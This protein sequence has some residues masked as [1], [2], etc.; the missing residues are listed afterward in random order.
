MGFGQAFAQRMPQSAGQTPLQIPTQSSSADKVQRSG[1]A[2]ANSPSGSQEPGAPESGGAE[3]AQD[4]L[5]QGIG[6]SKL[7]LT[8]ALVP[9]EGGAPVESP[10]QP[11]L[12]P[13]LEKNLCWCGLFTLWGGTTRH[14][15]A[16][17]APQR[18]DMKLDLSLVDGK[19]RV[20]LK[21]SG[22]EGLV[23][24]DESVSTR[25]DEDAVMGLVNRLV[26]RITGQPG[27]LGST[28]AFAMSQPG[29]PKVV[30]ATNTH[31]QTL[32]LV[33]RNREINILPR[34][35]PTGNALVYTVLGRD[36]SRVYFHNLA[37]GRD[38][39][40]PSRF[41]TEAG[42]LNT[43]GTFSPDGR[44]LVFTMSPNQNADLFLYDLTAAKVTQITS[45]IGIETQADWG[46]DGKQVLFV[47]DRSG[48]PQIYLMDLDTRE[49]LRLTFDGIYNTDPR[50]SPDGR[51]VLF[52]RRV[53][54]LD[55]IFIMDING[56]NIRPVTRGRFDAEQ[57]VWSPDGRQ[58]VFTSNRTG[59]YKLYVVSSDGSALR[60]LTTT[61]PGYEE[62]NPGW[63]LRRLI[64]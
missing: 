15:S 9:E 49:D 47:S 6:F 39:L 36:G 50:F 64:R 22:A 60:R 44:R 45:R 24:F 1:D 2:S 51:L 16:S 63:T 8:L 3:P 26:E 42:S 27:I 23:L 30:V 21:D 54:N 7:N 12:V 58:I 48:T 19:A 38:A 18:V 11:Y 41:L 17:G 57:A 29:Q 61:P 52:T 62:T 34:W 20:R 46:P 55:Q 59:E 4:I 13:L 25:A 33:S 35:S 53:D 14:C 10:E 37:T 28:I 5:I 56:E 43:G 32:Q 40:G 31:G